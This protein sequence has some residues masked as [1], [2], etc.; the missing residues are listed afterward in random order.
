M[1]LDHQPL[2]LIE[3]RYAAVLLDARDREFA[4]G[5]YDCALFALRVVEA[6]RNVKGLLPAAWRWE[7]AEEAARVLDS[8]GGYVAAV[9]AVLGPP[10]AKGPAFAAVGDVVLARDP[11][12]PSGRELLTV[13][14]GV[15]LVAPAAR[16]LSAIHRSNALVAWRT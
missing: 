15:Y 9:S 10:I 14:N 16:G 6:R 5:Q 3:Q 8:L 11:G 4:W 13:C 7:S 1:N 12:H 2:D